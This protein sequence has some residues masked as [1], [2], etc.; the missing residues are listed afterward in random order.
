M[1][2]FTNCYTIIIIITNITRGIMSECEFL[3]WLKINKSQ[4]KKILTKKGTKRVSI[5]K[6]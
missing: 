4:K 2:L 3:F 5:I 1:L 6:K